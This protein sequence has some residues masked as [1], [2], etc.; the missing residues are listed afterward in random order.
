MLALQNKCFSICWKI[1]EE[2]EQ[3]VLVV[4]LTGLAQGLKFICLRISTCLK[5]RIVRTCLYC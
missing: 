5:V 2:I 1:L 3:G 4:W